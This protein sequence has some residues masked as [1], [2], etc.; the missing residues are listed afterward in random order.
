[1]ELNG[2]MVICGV[3]LENMDIKIRKDILSIDLSGNVIAVSYLMV[4]LLTILVTIKKVIVCP[5][6]SY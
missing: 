1:M 2:K 4:K 3:W 6:Y 5:I